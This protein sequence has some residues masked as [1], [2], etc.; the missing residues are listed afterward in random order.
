[1]DDESL[2]AIFITYLCATNL[3]LGNV[4]QFKSLQIELD[5]VFNIVAIK[6]DVD[7]VPR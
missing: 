1:M 6:L 5:K 7:A 4:S 2:T 3:S